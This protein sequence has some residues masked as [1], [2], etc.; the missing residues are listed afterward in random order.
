MKNVEMYLYEI[1]GYFF[2]DNERKHFCKEL[3]AQDNSEA[4]AIV[5]GQLAWNASLED[6]AFKLDVIHYECL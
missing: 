2:A 1:S 4:M 5:I 6:K 3:Y